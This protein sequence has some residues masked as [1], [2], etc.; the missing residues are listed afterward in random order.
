MKISVIV[1]IYNVGVYL[2]ECLNSILTQTLEDIEIIAANDGSTDNS[3]EIA[4]KMAEADKR[5]KIVSHENMGL[6]PTRNDAMK[7]AQ[8]EYLA[9]VDSDD[10][11]SPDSLR[12]MYENA[13]K[14]NADIVVGETMM[15]DDTDSW[16]RKKLS[17]VNDILLNQQNKDLFYK[18]YYFNHVYSHN[19]WDKLYLSDF[20]FKHNLQFGDNK[21][22]FAEDNWF[23]LQAFLY[24]PK[25]SFVDIT[26]YWYRQQNES[27]MHK[28]KKELL[29]RHAQM[30]RDYSVLIKKTNGGDAEYKTM[31]ILS[32]EVL[33]AEAL[34]KKLT[35]SSIGDYLHVLGTISEKKELFDAICDLNK[36]KAYLYEN[37]SPKRFLYR[38]ISFLYNNNLVDVANLFMWFIYKHK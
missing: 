8:G 31:C 28:P 14:T 5:I 11:I 19:A 13:K 30:I 17:G 18:E 20:V 4:L 32:F 34:N 23:Q 38:I 10:R 1:P 9:F 15:F 16:I 36:K 37:N 21:R 35:N 7:Y 6:G 26:Y 2:E 29:N 22:I 27:I 33:I 3:L 25:I 12:I 24:N